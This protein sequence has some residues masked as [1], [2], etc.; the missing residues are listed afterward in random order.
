MVLVSRNFGELVGKN[1]E[2]LTLE[3]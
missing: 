3:T 2:P 1:I